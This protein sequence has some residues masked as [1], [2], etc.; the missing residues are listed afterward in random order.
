MTMNTGIAAS[1]GNSAD[2]PLRSWIRSNLHGVTW[3]RFGVFCLINIWNALA[4]WPVAR[5]LFGIDEA[6]SAVRAFA[7]LLAIYMVCYGLATLVL[8]VAANRAPDEP[9]RWVL[10]FGLACLLAG[11]TAT[12]F[13]LQV[14]AYPNAERMPYTAF[15]ANWSG[16]MFE[17]GIVGAVFLFLIHRD[18]TS[19][20]LQQE[21][22]D[23]I[24]VDQDLMQSRL[25]VLQ[26]QIEPHF[27]FNTVANIRWLLQTDRVA[28]KSMLQQFS[29]YV[30]AA[31]PQ[32]RD[33]QSSLGRELALASAY[34]S[35]Q[36]IRMGA[37]LATK[38]AVPDRLKA[39]AIPPMMLI[40]LVENAIKHG[41][42]PLP[43]G[44]SISIEATAENGRLVVRVVDSG[45]GLKVHSGSGI[46]IANTRN[47][48]QAL[49]RNA[50]RLAI[51][52]NPVAGVTATIE[53]PLA[54]GNPAAN[55]PC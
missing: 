8:I 29:R 38:I 7:L 24:A 28:G 46:G 13:V 10:P 51:S 16:G 50:A 55:Q 53:V 43:D 3:K 35:V 34:L 48:L 49:Y 42:A 11:L 15:F 17:A 14:F 39:A 41:L 1:A 9:R 5:A 36:Q 45:V 40:T 37:R 54:S 21:E 12:I 2:L 26:S 33:S 30:E 23:R 47:R 4:S 6:M 52:Q 25:Q 27:L 32:L 31:L 20:R 22:V 44:G 18:Q 19:A